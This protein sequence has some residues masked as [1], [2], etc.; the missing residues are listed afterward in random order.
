L[1]PVSTPVLAILT[2]WLCAWLNCAGWALSALG[3]L[4]AAGYAVSL[5]LFAA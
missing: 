2:V 3:Q 4:N 5:L 1:K